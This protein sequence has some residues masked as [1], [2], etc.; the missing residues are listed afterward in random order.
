MGRPSG[1]SRVECLPQSNGNEAMPDCPARETLEHFLAGALDDREE[2]DLCAHV[3]EC[4]ACQRKLDELVAG[5]VPRCGGRLKRGNCREARLD[6]SFLERLQLTLT[7]PDWRPPPWTEP[8][9]HLL[10]S[11]GSNG[12]HRAA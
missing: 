6:P 2:D 11:A 1:R 12:R 7:D 10:R 8:G 4:S 5:P 9:P 3:E